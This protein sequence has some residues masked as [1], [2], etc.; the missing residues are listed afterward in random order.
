MPVGG[1]LPLARPFPLPRLGPR[2]PGVQGR[3]AHLATSQSLTP[4]VPTDTATA[5]DADATCHSGSCSHPPGVSPALGGFRR[6]PVTTPRLGTQEGLCDGQDLTV[7]QQGGQQ[8][9]A[10][11]GAVLGRHS[12]HDGRGHHLYALRGRFHPGVAGPAERRVP[13]VEKTAAVAS[14]FERCTS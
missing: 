4:D 14:G 1:P 6:R 2:V 12:A 11:H 5:T 13:P 9:G 7:G 3:S 10:G 8:E